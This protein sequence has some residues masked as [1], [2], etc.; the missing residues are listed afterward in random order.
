MALPDS[1]LGPRILHKEKLLT[2]K[3]FHIDHGIVVLPGQAEA[4]FFV[5]CQLAGPQGYEDIAVIESTQSSSPKGVACYVI[6]SGVRII[7]SIEFSKIM[8][9]ILEKNGD[10]TFAEIFA[11]VSILLKPT[12]PFLNCSRGSRNHPSL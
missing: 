7:V 10:P 4:F 1:P 8:D 5:W 11:L 12:S 3:L 2:F 6:T 9:Q